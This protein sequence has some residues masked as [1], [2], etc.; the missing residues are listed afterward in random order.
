[1]ARVAASRQPW[2]ENAASLNENKINHRWRRVV[3]LVYQLSSL[4]SQL[5]LVQE[6]AVA[7]IA[8]LDVP[9]YCGVRS[10]ISPGPCPRGNSPSIYGLMQRQGHQASPFD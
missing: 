4:K 7:C 10:I 5:C 2:N 1:M 9:V 3:S 6:P 8:W